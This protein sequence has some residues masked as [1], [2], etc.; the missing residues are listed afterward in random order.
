LTWPDDTAAFA[1]VVL[2]LVEFDREKN[3]WGWKDIIFDNFVLS[4][5]QF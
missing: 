2:G 1:V 3:R 5:E 4:V